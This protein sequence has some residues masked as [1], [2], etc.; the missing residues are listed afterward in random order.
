MEGVGDNRGGD[1]SENAVPDS[2]VLV[3]EASYMRTQ[4]YL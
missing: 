1:E 2:D 4:R 3:C